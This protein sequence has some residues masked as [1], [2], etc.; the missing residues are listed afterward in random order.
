MNQKEIHKILRKYLR[1]WARL[2]KAGVIRS[3]NMTA[4]LGEHYAC[5]K[6]KLKQVEP[7]NRGYDAIKKRK[8]YEV[9][10]RKAPKKNAL[11]STYMIAN[12]KIRFFDYLVLVNLDYYYRLERIITIPKHIAKKYIRNNRIR[13]GIELSKEKGVKEKTYGEGWE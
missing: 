9:K 12:K 5:A 8:K 11:P 2:K 3:N 10:T 6:L 7:L 4:D 1:C 13:Y